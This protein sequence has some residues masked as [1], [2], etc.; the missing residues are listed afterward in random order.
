[1]VTSSTV[2]PPF[3]PAITCPPPADPL[4]KPAHRRPGGRE[5]LN[6]V[7]DG[8]FAGGQR[9]GLGRPP[10]RQLRLLS[11]QLGRRPRDG[12]V[13]PALADTRAE[14]GAALTG[15]VLFI[16]GLAC[17]A[18]QRRGHGLSVTVNTSALDNPPA[19]GGG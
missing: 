5:Q 14:Q 15:E 9:G 7:G 4:E 8:V 3:Y 11:T 6:R 1:M 13:A 18:N 12:G 17:V 19:R 2:L 10:S 16:H